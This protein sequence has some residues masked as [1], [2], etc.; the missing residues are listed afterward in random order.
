MGSQKAA[1]RPGNEK[2]DSL[3]RNRFQIRGKATFLPHLHNTLQPQ[4]FASTSQGQKERE[5]A[6]SPSQ[7]VSLRKSRRP[8]KSPIFQNEIPHIN[9]M[10]TLCVSGCL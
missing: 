10:Q 8:P 2:T 5:T 6:Y 1:A 3:L 9:L 7:A 4:A